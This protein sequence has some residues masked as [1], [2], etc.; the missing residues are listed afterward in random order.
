MCKYLFSSATNRGC[1][2]LFRMLFLQLFGLFDVGQEK[3]DTFKETP[4]SAR[5]APAFPRC[6]DIFQ[7]SE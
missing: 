7:L 6:C 4:V 3:V 1:L 5:Q 2:K